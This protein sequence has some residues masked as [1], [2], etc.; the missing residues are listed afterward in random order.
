MV[1][2]RFCDLQTAFEVIKADLHSDTSVD[3]TDKSS[4][5]DFFSANE[6]EYAILFS[7]YTDVD[8]AEKQ[9][10]D[11]S[12]SA[13]K[14]NVDGTQ[15][16]VDACK[17]NDR[18]LIFISTDFV[19]DGTSGPYSEDAIRAEDLDKISWYG[20]TKIRGEE[21]AETLKSHLIVRI[22]Y[23]YRS[24]FDS[25]IDFARSILKKYDDGE[26]Y[27]MF[28][29][30]HITPTYV[31]D[32]APALE[33]IISKECTGIYHL[34]SPELV[35][36]HMFA[37]FLLTKFKGENIK[38]ESASIV[39]FLKK[40]GATPRPVNAGLKTGKISSLGFEP[41]SWRDGI[42]KIYKDIAGN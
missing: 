28:S 7:A 31:D 39:E 14:V 27:P 35:T 18:K 25:K 33:L 6:F 12:E 3:I 32:I 40:E 8:G 19:F 21:T 17:E 36:P 10:G 34:A 22:S 13:W 16:V 24:K 11:K 38:L 26:L 5:E 2:S 20:F 4:V 30:Q 1:G 42:D 23:P 15:N 37:E 9:S 29:D 41:T